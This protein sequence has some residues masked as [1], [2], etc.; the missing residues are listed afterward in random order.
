MK[1]DVRAEFRSL[2]LPVFCLAPEK[3]WLVSQSVRN[4]FPP[5]KT[6]FINGP[7]F[8]L[9]ARPKESGALVRQALEEVLG[10]KL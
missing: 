10:E 8:I 9:Q 1:V 4:D 2:K 6:E 7:H 5:G 3:D